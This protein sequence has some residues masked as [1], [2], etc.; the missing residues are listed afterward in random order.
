[1][2]RIVL[3][4]GGIDSSAVSA[5][6]RPDVAVVVD[7]GQLPA[8]GEIRS[9][10]A[11]ANALKIPVH[12]ISANCSELGSGLLLGQ[13][14]PL[15]TAPTTEWWP[16]RNQLLITLVGAWAVKFGF[17][18]LVTGSV[19]GD[20]RHADGSTAFYSGIDRLMSIQ[21]G[22]IRVTAPA[23][24]LTSVDLV[25]ISGISREILGWTHSCHRAEWACGTCP[26]CL[27]HVEVISQLPEL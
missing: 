12:V 19:R 21:E 9:A 13:E 11:V 1:M 3:L 27:K 17:N 23:I 10:T 6:I 14:T 16:F 22:C 4:S 18:E 26:G 7:Y 8:K 20:D 5:W 15:K 25:H 2:S 24:A